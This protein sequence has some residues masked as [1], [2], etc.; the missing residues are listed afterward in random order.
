MVVIRYA[1]TESIQ[2]YEEKLGIDIYADILTKHNI[3]PDQIKDMPEGK[4][5]LLY[6][7]M[8]KAYQ[9]VKDEE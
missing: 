7:D 3:D 2:G 9:Q 5:M 6:Q 1:I 8:E 4:G